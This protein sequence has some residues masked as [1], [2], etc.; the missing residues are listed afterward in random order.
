ML[1]SP[2]ANGPRFAR[3]GGGRAGRPQRG[4]GRPLARAIRYYLQ[5]FPGS[6]DRIVNSPV[7]TRDLQRDVLQIDY[8]R[9]PAFQTQ[10]EPARVSTEKLLRFDAAYSAASAKLKARQQTLDEA[11]RQL[12]SLL[13]EIFGDILGQ[14]ADEHER[15]FF[16]TLKRCVLR[17]MREHLQ[18]YSAGTW[19]AET[20]DLPQTARE[21]R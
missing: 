17:Q 3:S 13:D 16:D 5:S 15:L 18:V 2:V 6:R 8:S 12:Q 21:L 9:H 20:A 19:P 1:A 7:A 10:D 11:T 4:R 14:V